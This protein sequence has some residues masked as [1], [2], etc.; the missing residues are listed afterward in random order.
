MPAISRENR[1]LGANYSMWMHD[2]V[3]KP[4]GG[5]SFAPGSCVG[6]F[7]FAIGNTAWEK[8]EFSKEDFPTGGEKGIWPYYRPLNMS[9]SLT[10]TKRS[11]S[12]QSTSRPTADLF[13]TS[14]CSRK[15]QSRRPRQPP[16]YCGRLVQ[17][18]R[19]RPEHPRPLYARWYLLMLVL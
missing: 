19:I 14:A 8:I 18:L 11:A 3:D 15:L 7:T 17:G 13:K 12:G 16:Y 4:E 10:D 5:M 2:G 9:K 6:I 1:G